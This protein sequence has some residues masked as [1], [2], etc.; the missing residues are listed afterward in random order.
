MDINNWIIYAMIVVYVRL[1]NHNTFG[2]IEVVRL[3]YIGGPCSQSF[4][5]AD[6]LSGLNLT[7]Y[8]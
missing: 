3:R 7:Y 4:K 1:Y 6:I 8:A 5:G 2:F